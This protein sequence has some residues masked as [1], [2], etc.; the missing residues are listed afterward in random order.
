MEK[1]GLFKR[2]ILQREAKLERSFICWLNRAPPHPRM[3]TIAGAKQIQSKARGRYLWSWVPSRSFVV[4]WP[5]PTHL[6][7]NV[8]VFV[9]VI[10][11]KCPPEF[12]MDG[13]SQQNRQSSDKV[14]RSERAGE[15]LT[16]EPWGGGKL[17]LCVRFSGSLT[18]HGVSHALLP[19]SAFPPLPCSAFWKCSLRKKETLL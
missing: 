5:Q 8:S 19:S 7:V 13:S 15:T 14:L 18:Q 12:F 16:T 4:P 11:I 10:Q 9:D 17:G 2:Q 1:T 3:A 6:F